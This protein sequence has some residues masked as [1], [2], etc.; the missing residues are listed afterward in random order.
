MAHGLL[1][2]HPYGGWPRVPLWV[3]AGPG[4]GVL[5]GIPGIPP[6]RAPPPAPE[7]RPLGPW[8]PRPQAH[9]SSVGPTHTS[10][11]FRLRVSLAHPPYLQPTAAPDPVPPSLST[12][13]AFP[14]RAA[15]AYASERKAV[16]P[17]HLQN[18]LH[19]CSTASLRTQTTLQA[20]FSTKSLCS[21]HIYYLGISR[22]NGASYPNLLSFLAAPG[23]TRG[24]ERT[25]FVL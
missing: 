17:P 22:M 13:Q 16:V 11:Q 24:L 5:L 21:S 10:V 2:G 20:T 25:Q 18:P 19:W 12:P 9:S 15:L 14:C 6:N 3:L 7:D 1:T 8:D 4:A 23:R